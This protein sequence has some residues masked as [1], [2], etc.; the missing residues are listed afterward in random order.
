MKNESLNVFKN[1]IKEVIEIN[2]SNYDCLG[3]FINKLKQH[4]LLRYV[5]KYSHKEISKAL[6]IFKSNITI[7]IARAK[8]KLRKLLKERGVKYEK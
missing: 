7:R 5:S 6:D 3:K 1:Y 4:F 8:N 2:S